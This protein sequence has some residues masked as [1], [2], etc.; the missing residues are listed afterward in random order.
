MKQRRPQRGG[1]LFLPLPLGEGRGEG[2]G[3][4]SETSALLPALRSICLVSVSVITHNT[5]RLFRFFDVS[6]R[7]P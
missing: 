2:T 6:K 7:T 5:F 4:A 1:A 3:P